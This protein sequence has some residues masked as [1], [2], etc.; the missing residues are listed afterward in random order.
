MPCGLLQIC[1][2]PGHCGQD[3]KRI[4]TFFLTC[5]LH[6]RVRKCQTIQT[7]ETKLQLYPTINE[8]QPK[9]GKSCK[10]PA[11]T[12]PPWKNQS[13]GESLILRNS[14]DCD[15]CASNIE[16]VDSWNIA[17]MWLYGK[18]RKNR[19]KLKCSMFFRSPYLMGKQNA[20]MPSFW[21]QS[22][23]DLQE[24]EITLQFWIA[25]FSCDCLFLWSEVFKSHIEHDQTQ[26]TGEIGIEVYLRDTLKLPRDLL[27]ANYSRDSDMCPGMEAHHS[28]RTF[29]A[30]RIWEDYLGSAASCLREAA[31]PSRHLFPL[32]TTHLVNN[33]WGIFVNPLQ[34]TRSCKVMIRSFALPDPVLHVQKN[35]YPDLLFAKAHYFLLENA[36]ALNLDCDSKFVKSKSVLL[37][38]CG[39]FWGS[40]LSFL[41][42]GVCEEQ[43]QNQNGPTA[44]SSY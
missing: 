27:F 9:E 35:L 37:L 1:K 7:S 21:D 11:V 5:S 41:G 28:G 19:S 30:L 20:F 43:R 22:T 18:W 24:V 31:E 6:W 2:M 12:G 44:S 33:R 15:S 14:H 16:S 8:R 38:L 40:V 32:T 39:P 29:T 25:N 23:S 10:C 13:Q 3:L 42:E 4:A 34:R 17:F 36:F 26:K